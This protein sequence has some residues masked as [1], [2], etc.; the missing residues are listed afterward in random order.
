MENAEAAR[1]NSQKRPM[2]TDERAAKQAFIGQMLDTW[3][4][5]SE[6]NKTVGIDDTWN[7]DGDH[8]TVE[9][10]KTSV[11]YQGPNTTDEWPECPSPAQD[12]PD[13]VVDLGP[14]LF[15]DRSPGEQVFE[16]YKTLQ[17]QRRRLHRE[18]IEG[19]SGILLRDE[20]RHR[21]N[22]LSPEEQ[23]I[24]QRHVEGSTLTRGRCCALLT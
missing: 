5:A 8:L 7:V 17:D 14:L 11:V 1:T 23:H 22:G 4:S 19:E 18:S 24:Q 21:K 6:A 15:E 16:D 3:S 9:P 2:T 12:V 10:H 13:G 20:Y